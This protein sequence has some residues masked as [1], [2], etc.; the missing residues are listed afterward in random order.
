LFLLKI[1]RCR[2]FNKREKEL[3]CHSVCQVRP[4]TGMVT[5]AKDEAD[6]S[7]TFDGSYDENVRQVVTLSY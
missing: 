5:L 7:F 6:K 2:P 3:G 4:D 1:G